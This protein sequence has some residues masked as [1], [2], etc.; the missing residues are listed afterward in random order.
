MENLLC[1]T[2]EGNLSDLQS[3]QRPERD[4][5]QNSFKNRSLVW[6]LY[7]DEWTHLFGSTFCF[8]NLASFKIQLSSFHIADHK[9]AFLHVMR[10]EMKKRYSHNLLLLG[11]FL[12]ANISI[13]NFVCL[14]FSYT[15]QNENWK[16][17]YQIKVKYH[18]ASTTGDSESKSAYHHDKACT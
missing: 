5:V 16:I 7:I 8:E 9:S 11:H 6:Y 2:D 14:Q 1:M 10:W 17:P 13:S 15:P 3:A 4:F 18:H 12:V